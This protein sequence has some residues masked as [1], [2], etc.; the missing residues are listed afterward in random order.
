MY[1]VRACEWYVSTM[2]YSLDILFWLEIDLYLCV[3]VFSCMVVHSIHTLNYFF[4]LPPPPP[5]STTITTPPPPPTPPPPA[6]SQELS[7]TWLHQDKEYLSSDSL[8]FATDGGE[9][10]TTTI[11]TNTSSE[12]GHD[13]DD[14]DDHTDS[15]AAAAAA[16]GIVG[17]ETGDGTGYNF[18]RLD[19]RLALH[20]MMNVF[21]NNEEF[22]FKCE[23]NSISV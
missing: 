18:W 1:N 8:T 9:T 11:I 10:T 4:L 17:E 15:N 7:Q 12:T 22:K 6:L 19:H 5:F 14:D 16:E 23:V 2:V 21:D 13:G 3:C 20:L